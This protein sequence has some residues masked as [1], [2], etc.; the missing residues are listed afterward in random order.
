MKLEIERIAD[1]FIV[2]LGE[3]TPSGRSLAKYFPEYDHVEMWKH[4]KGK[5]KIETKSS[6]KK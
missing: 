2:S 6:G 4:V 3:F 5:L 1:G